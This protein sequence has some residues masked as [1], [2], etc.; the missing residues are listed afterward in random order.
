M[1]NN[2]FNQK[3]VNTGLLGPWMTSRGFKVKLLPPLRSC[4]IRRNALNSLNGVTNL[5]QSR[6]LPGGAKKLKQIIFR[7]I[8][9]NVAWFW[10]VLAETQAPNTTQYFCLGKDL[11]LCWQK[12]LF[13]RNVSSVKA[14]YHVKLIKILIENVSVCYATTLK[15]DCP[16]YHIVYYCLHHKGRYHNGRKDFSKALRQKS[17]FCSTSFMKPHYALH[18]VCPSQSQYNICT[19]L[20]SG[21][22][23]N[24]IIKSNLM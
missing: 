14:A 11:L 16:W 15:S 8:L 12:D 2:K 22:K 1:W 9:S 20:D 6:K 17:L 7:I 19:I 18:T 24:K 21:A 10:Y 13:L 3:T 23:Q 5:P 4:Q